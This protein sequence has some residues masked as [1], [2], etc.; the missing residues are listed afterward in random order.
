VDVALRSF[1]VKVKVGQMKR[2]IVDSESRA[3]VTM[4]NVILAVC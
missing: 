4:Q 3:T 1:H 2:S